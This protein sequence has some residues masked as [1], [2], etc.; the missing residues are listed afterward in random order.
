MNFPESRIVTLPF[1]SHVLMSGSLSPI[2]IALEFLE[3]TT[4]GNTLESLNKESNEFQ[5][6][7]GIKFR[8]TNNSVIY[9]VNTEKYLIE[10]YTDILNYEYF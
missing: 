6:I 8:Y 9:E 7:E 5:I 1:T 10:D 2:N 3:K 4:V